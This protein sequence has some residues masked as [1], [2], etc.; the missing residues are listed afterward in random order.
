MRMF[1]GMLLALLAAG[2]AV[3]GEVEHQ[4]GEYRFS[5]D[6][7]PA[8]VET[9]QLPASWDAKAP[10]GTDATWRT[11]WIDEQVDRRGGR[12]Q[13]YVDYAYEAKAASL[14]GNAGRYDIEFNPGYQKLVIHGVELRR[15]GGWQDRLAPDRISLA[16]R[17]QEFEQDTADGNVAAL[18]V[19]DDVRVDDVVRIRYS[20]IG[21][22]PILGGQLLDW[23]S[24]G[25]QSPVLWA[26]LRV[27][28]DPGAAL[29]VRRLGNAPEVKVRSSADGVE[30]SAY[31]SRVPGYI[32][33]GAYPLWYRPA[34][35]VY[36]SPKRSWADVVTWA[37]P[38]Y[39]E[40]GPLP[41]DLEAELAKWSK[42][43]D[44]NAKIRA[45]LRAV[46]NQ[47]RYFGVEMGA[48]THRPAAPAET[49][50]RRYGD[51]KDKA[52]LLSVLLGRMGIEAVPALVSTRRGKGIAD[53]PS[54]ASVFDHVIVRVQVDG[55]KSW[56]DPTSTAEGGDPRDSDQSQYGMALPIRAGIAALDTIDPP[57]KA[58][59]AVD[60]DERYEPLAD[61]AQ[62][63]LSIDTTYE[64]KSADGMRR[65]FSGQR[66]E[67]LS[68]RYAE[69]YR[70]RFGDID[71]VT[72]LNI[73][74]DQDA[75]RLQVSER[76]LLKAPFKAEGSSRV[77]ETYAEVVAG[78]TVL[79]DSMQRNAP[80]VMGMPAH[81]RHRIGVSL[82][83]RWTTPL[84]DEAE[85]FQS[86]AFA[87][88][89]DLTVKG[90]SIGVVHD[91]RVLERDVPKD[92]ATAHLA[93]LRKVRDDLS[94][95]L[96]LSVPPVEQ[97]QKRERND[98]LKALLKDISEK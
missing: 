68:R 30:A 42:L 23:N 73:K 51:C 6:A 96:T 11:W 65:S 27:F 35:V 32:D 74:D 67:Q 19:L 15:N 3:A 64:G 50:T 66:V 92:R 54:A 84:G 58:V 14:L 95:R 47:V 97:E 76:Y 5:T 57:E 9:R 72:P 82:P 85:R 22:N 93:E 46:Q 55:H 61:G 60:V 48:N 26:G 71:V 69:Y 81:Y 36:I 43:P 86:E 13:V 90:R 91:L 44:P 33:E 52:Y 62:V 59:S 2:T 31:A 37:L 4:R 45:A 39:P 25:W 49:W 75:G 80:V 29:D 94:L 10:G 83:E 87:Y 89:R 41:K 56:V 53:M 98:R 16:R 38:L 88:Q 40:V 70:K 21:S 1:S 28:H 63:R 79:P 20:I 24:F 7:V 17:E 77:L 18:I 34:P 8:F 12:D 78:P